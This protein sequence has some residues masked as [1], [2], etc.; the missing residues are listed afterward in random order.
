MIGAPAGYNANLGNFCRAGGDAFSFNWGGSGTTFHFDNNTFIGYNSTVLD[1]ACALQNSGTAH[2]SDGGEKTLRNNV[3]V[4]YGSNTYDAAQAPGMFCYSDC[5]NSEN[6]PVNDMPSSP[7]MWTARSNNIFYNMRSCP[8]ST[9]SNEN[10]NDPGLTRIPSISTPLTTESQLD[11]TNLDLDPISTSPLISAGIAVAG[12]TTDYNGASRGNPST[13]G[14][15]EIAGSGGGTPPPSDTTPPTTSIS[16]PTAGATVSGSIS[17]SASASDNVGVTSVQFYVDGV[18]KTSDNTSPY[19]F[20]LDTT[21]LSNGTHT[22]QTRA[23]DGAG[24]MGSSQ[25]VNITVSN[26]VG[27]TPTSTPS[28]TNPTGP[29]GYTFCSMELQTCTMSGTMN[30]AY[31]YGTSFVYQVITGNFYC[32]ISLFVTDPA[33]NILKA[34]F[35]APLS[36]PTS[37]PDTTPPTAS[38]TSPTSG[39]TVSGTVNVV[40]SAADNVGVTSVTFYVDGVVKGTTATAPYNFSLDTKTLTNGAHL[41]AAR[42][43]DAANNTV[44]SASIPVTVSNSASGG[45]GGTS[46]GGSGGGG[47]TPAPTPPPSFGITSV[48]VSSVTTSTAQVTIVTHVPASIVVKY[49]M[50]TSYGTMTGASPYLTT[51]YVKLTNLSPGTTYDF[52]VLA[53]TEGGITIT[54]QQ[55]TLTTQGGTAGGTAT[56]PSSA[57]VFTTPLSSGTSGASV[58]LLQGILLSQGFLPTKIL[59]T[60][61]FGTQT[62][63]ALMLFQSAH[64]LPTTGYLDPQTETLLNKVAAGGGTSVTTTPGTTP[65]PATGSGSLTQNLFPGSTGS[66]VTILQHLLN[67]DGDYPQAIYTT[68]YGALTQKA[69]QLFQTKYGIVSYGTPGTTGYGAVGPK[70]RGRLNK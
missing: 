38:V 20:F 21:S 36:T 23:S 5:N 14:A 24:N 8:V 57:S 7:S 48:A 1:I 29:A 60:G 3:F 50:T 69:V 2:C 70:T 53:S 30:V 18:L 17:V 35:I 52:V 44:T 28:S 64:N 16:S 9:F 42:A 63:H 10:C 47:G 45:T 26:S 27:T 15:I 41:F 31:G 56:S 68:F 33:R 4:G 46:G 12:L 11:W 39:S 51:N 59:V 55:Y 32:S 58:T 43:S 49:G 40:I 6:A 67:Q 25:S 19:S 37:T 65:T 22:L 13:I 54:S 66:Q 61:Y 62:T 34:C